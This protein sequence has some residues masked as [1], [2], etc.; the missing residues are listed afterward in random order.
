VSRTPDDRR[1]RVVLS[2]AQTGG[3][4]YAALAVASALR[5]AGCDVV[6]VVSGAKAEQT[7]LEG[8]DFPMETL[9]VGKLKGMG[10]AR[11]LLGAVSIPG[12]VL[13]ARLM[14]KRLKPDVVVGFGGYTTGPLLLAA[15]LGRIPTGICEENAVPG[16]ANRLLSGIVDKV[17][18]AYERAA[19]MMGAKHAIRTGVP[20]RPEITVLPA[21]VWERAGR[22]I[23]VLGGSQGAR[24]LNQRLPTVLGRVAEMLDG[25]LE[26]LHQTGAGTVDDTEARYREAGV[27]AEVMPYLHD[28]AAAYGAADLAICR[29]GA[30][31]VSELTAVGIPAL[32]VPFPAAADDHQTV[33]AQAVV[34]AGGAW[35]TQE[36]AFDDEAVAVRVAALLKDPS[37]LSAMAA[38]SRSWGRRDGRE[39]IAA[40]IIELVRLSSGGNRPKGS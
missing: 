15:V 34:D 11:G 37:G 27:R 4:L 16:L 32:F 25:H 17:F 24:F 13:S 8:V 12:A 5:E 38:A 29:A 3:H 22:R 2:G 21:R 30:G 20:V 23:L 26:V 40:E 19:V 10:V 18:V 36:A 35:M 33:N 39:A 14:L 28:M 31:T 6:L 1:I 7:I 9:S